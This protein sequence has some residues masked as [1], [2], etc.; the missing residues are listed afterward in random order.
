M[1]ISK[2]RMVNK[3]LLEIKNAN[4]ISSD[5]EL[6]LQ[7]KIDQVT[8][9]GNPELLNLKFTYNNET[10]LDL[11][12]PIIPFVYNER[13]EKYLDVMVRTGDPQLV[14]DIY[15]DVK[16]IQKLTNLQSALIFKLTLLITLFD[17]KLQ[18]LTLKL[19]TKKI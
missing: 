18:V 2:K 9:S 6:Y 13:E 14:R 19:L 1:I 7:Q 11:N 4:D 12:L 17:M 3:E 15:D 8:M 5:F 10:F 16:R